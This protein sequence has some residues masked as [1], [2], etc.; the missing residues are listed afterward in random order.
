MT[1]NSDIISVPIYIGMQLESLQC[2]FSGHNKTRYYKQFHSQYL[3][4]HENMSHTKVTIQMFIAALF[5]IGETFM[6]TP[7]EL[8]N[9]VICPYNRI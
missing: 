6:S 1:K 4:G 2:L 5:I 8:I 3:P 9:Q 7:D